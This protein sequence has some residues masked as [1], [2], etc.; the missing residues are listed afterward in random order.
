VKAFGSPSDPG[1]LKQAIRRVLVREPS[2]TYWGIG[3][4]ALE[5]SPPDPGRRMLLDYS[6][7]VEA[8]LTWFPLGG[9]YRRKT[10]NTRHSIYELKHLGEDHTGR[11]ISAGAFIT[12]ALILG[13][14]YELCGQGPSCFI[15]LHETFIRLSEKK[16]QARYLKGLPYARKNAQANP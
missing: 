4:Y 9:F 13:F 11:Y 14:R 15:N 16:R 7:E 1:R 2:L 5:K 6:E 8:A 3:P 10:V 12:A